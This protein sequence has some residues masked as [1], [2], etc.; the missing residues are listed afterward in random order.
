MRR[1][2]LRSVPFPEEA[3]AGARPLVLREG[4]HAGPVLILQERHLHH[5]A[6]FLRYLERLLNAGAGS[7]G[8]QCDGY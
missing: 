4:V 7:E 5:A 1:L 8:K 6:A 3:A 2:R